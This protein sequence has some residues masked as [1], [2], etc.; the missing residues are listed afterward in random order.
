MVGERCAG[1]R[2][3]KDSCRVSIYSNID[4]NIGIVSKVP[5]L[6]PPINISGYMIYNPVATEETVKV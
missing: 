6:S 2:L 1:Q 5:N 3:G 4:F